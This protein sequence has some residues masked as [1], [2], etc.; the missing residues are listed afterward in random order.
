MYGYQPSP[1]AHCA[2]GL[3]IEGTCPCVAGTWSPGAGGSGDLMMRVKEARLTNGKAPQ[4]SWT[5]LAGLSQSGALV[6][7]ATLEVVSSVDSALWRRLGGRARGRLFALGLA[8]ARSSSGPG[9][10]EWLEACPQMG[11]GMNC[12]RPCVLFDAPGARQGMV[13]ESTRRQRPEAVSG[14]SRDAPQ[15]AVGTD[16]ARTPRGDGFGEGLSAAAAL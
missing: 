11:S 2:P 4:F 14:D 3:A 1:G 6:I 9:R 15:L 10:S 13:L 8:R 7:G 5:A 12:Q 16:S